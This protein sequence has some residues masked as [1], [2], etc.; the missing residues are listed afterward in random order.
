MRRLLALLL[1][2]PLLA[3]A[4]PARATNCSLEALEARHLE[5]LDRHAAGDRAG[6]WDLWRPLAE[7]GFPPA[8]RHLARHLITEGVEDEAALWALAAAKSGDLDGALLARDLVAEMSGSQ[9]TDLK[10]RLHERPAPLA[11]CFGT[12]WPGPLRDIDPRTLSLGTIEVHFGARIDDAAIETI[13]DVLPDVLR[14]AREASPL[15]ALLLRGAGR[16]EILASRMRHRYVGWKTGKFPALRLSAEALLDGH[17]DILGRTI[18]TALSRQTAREL[19][20]FRQIDPATRIAEGKRLVGSPYPDIDSEPFFTRLARVLEHA[21]ALPPELLKLVEAIDAVHYVPESRYFSKHDGV[22]TVA[23]FY[24]ARLGQEG[25]RMVFVRR[26]MKWTSDADLLLLLVHEGTHAA[27]HETVGHYRRTGIPEQQAAMRLFPIGSKN[28]KILSRKIRDMS[29]YVRAWTGGG[30][31]A[32]RSTRMRFECEATINE[33]HAAQAINA[34]PELV[35]DSQYLK[36]CEEAR[37]LVVQWREKRLR[38]GLRQQAA[39]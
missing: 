32:G 18:A 20:D 31:V 37:T 19:R 38:K 24:D 15:G 3:A 13:A 7:A 14:R 2:L 33:I 30:V 16:I 29:D 5:A 10:L 4:G 8:Q 12:A 23:A 1:L 36:L 6:A 9:V 11:G 21:K 25:N 26:D 17:P 28:R 22:D 34:P 39:R 27:Q 35:E